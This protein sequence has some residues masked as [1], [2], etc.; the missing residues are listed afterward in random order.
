MSYVRMGDDSDVYLI[1][2]VRDASVIECCGCK[3]NTEKT[4]EEPA[5]LVEKYPYPEHWIRGLWWL[6]NPDPVFTSAAAVLQHLDAHRA[7]GHK[8]PER[9]YENIS[10][11]ADGWLKEKK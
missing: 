3:F 8:V 10:R 4:Q 11:R 9:A 1:G 7:A 6:V 2:T 5:W